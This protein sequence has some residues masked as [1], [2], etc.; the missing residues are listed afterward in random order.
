M[1]LSAIINY[2]LG[3]LGLKIGKKDVSLRRTLP[4]DIAEDQQFFNVYK[5]IKD[6]TL[7]EP[8][9]CYALY[10]AVQYIIQNNLT[11]DF[12][13][14]GVWKGGSCMLIAMTLLELNV[15]DRKIWLYD[16]F[17]G[18]TKPGLNDGLEEKGEWEEK[19]TGDDASNWCLASLEEVK[20]NLSSTSYP[21]EQFVFVQGKVEETIP[22]NI[23]SSVALLRLDTDWYDSTKHELQHLYPL[24][25]KGGILLID[26]YGA[27]QGARKATDEYF[28]D[29]VLLNR[30]DWTG[31]LLIK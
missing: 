3:L 14:C 9:R 22:G 31:R 12:V 19:K 24:L 2:P 7:V 10:K 28:G 5:R 23:P 27:W 4:A 8:E 20:K 29:K 16:T 25:T 18:M 1:K 21:F 6:F 15:S 13:E 30:I 26:D 11:G 17:T